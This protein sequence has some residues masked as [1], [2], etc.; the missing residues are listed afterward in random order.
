[1]YDT[2]SNT[3]LT[4][5]GT[6][7]FIGGLEVH[8]DTLPFDVTMITGINTTTNVREVIFP[9][10]MKQADY[11]GTVKDTLDLRSDTAT[12]RCGIVDLGSLSWTY[13]NN[14][15]FY[16]V[17]T[18]MQRTPINDQTIVAPM[19][20]ASYETTSRL[21]VMN[22]NKSISAHS[23]GGNMTLNVYNTAYT[24]ATALTTALQGILLCFVLENPVTYTDLQDANGNPINPR[25]K[26]EQ[27]G[28]E[29]VLPIN[30]S[31]P[32]TVAPTLTTTYTKDN[33]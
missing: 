7:T 32:T 3:F 19:L 14:N 26:V 24:D 25:Y 11:A 21:D 2:V 4:N 12:V 10:G 30:T 23:N 16:A 8:L 5:A 31:T 15:R 9:N 13:A 33:N 17:Y 18:E 28:T 20:C 1:M 6:G 29:Q 22:E 27:G